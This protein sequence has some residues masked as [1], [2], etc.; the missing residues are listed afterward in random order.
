MEKLEI[1]TN[2]EEITED[3]SIELSDNRGEEAENNE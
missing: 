3:A 2:I 1:I